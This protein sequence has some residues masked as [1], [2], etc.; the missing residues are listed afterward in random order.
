M[1]KMTRLKA[2]A[3]HLG[4]SLIIFLFMLY[5]ILVEWYPPP[6]FALDGGWQGIRIIAGVD[7]VL[8]P[9]LTLIV[10][11]PGK[12]GLKFDLSVIALVQ[13]GA[14]IYGSW[15]V[16]NERPVAVIFVEDRFHTV[17]A[18]Q[19]LQAGFE[20]SELDQ[21]GDDL[22]V[23]IYSHLPEDEAELTR[24]RFE[25]IGAQKPLYFLGE[26][27]EPVTQENR[28][29]IISMAIDMKSYLKDMPEELAVYEGYIS[30]NG[31]EILFYPLISRYGKVIVGVNKDSLAFLSSLRITPPEM[32]N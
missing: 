10:F 26:Y 12:P 32:K 14:L 17:P 7:L 6:L 28:E 15:L 31:D 21:F 23:M 13:T 29:K 2:F 16:Q 5:I 27:Y 19:V 22:P 30:A 4:I 1:E 11:K 3:T 9:L 25:A 8:G 18:F 20:V 24:V